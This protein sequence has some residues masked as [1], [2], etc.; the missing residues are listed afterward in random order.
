M[1]KE[2]T[3]EQF[4]QFKKNF[5]FKSMYQNTSYMEVMKNQGFEVLLLGLVD[6]NNILAATM[7]LLEKKGKT[8]YGYVPRGYLIDYNNFNLLKQ[9]TT[10]L[11]NYLSNYNVLS[12]KLCPPIFRSITDTKYNITNYNNYYDNVFYN[13]TE[14]GYKHLG[15]NDYFEALKPRFEA[16]IDISMPYYMLFNNIK[17]EYRTKIRSA[18]NK[19]IKIYKGDINTI[20]ILYEQIKSKYPRNFEF[21]K[22]CYLKYEKNAEILYAKL[23]TKYYL[24][25]MQELY[26]NQE[27]ECKYLN[28][29]ISSRN[30]DNEKYVHLKMIADKKLNEYRKLIVKATKYLKE[31]PEGIICSTAL[32]LKDNDEV[33]ILTDGIDKK[34]REL[35]SKHLLIWKIMEEYSKK[36]YKI[37]NL[38]AISNPNILNNKYSGLNTFKINYN[39]LCYEYVGD[40]ELICNDKFSLFKNIKFKNILKI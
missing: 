10:E 34:Y 31:N 21:F 8:R 1:I 12:I 29:Q 20:N 18:E 13:L 37:L 26:I 15:Y 6:N 40:F 39:A 23:D 35:N 38:G 28:T 24:N 14:L 25:K 32:V 9:F 27:N 16:I 11:K 17:K 36:G 22:D 19:G 30:K 4:N 5:N 2:L 3:I 7:I 33:Y